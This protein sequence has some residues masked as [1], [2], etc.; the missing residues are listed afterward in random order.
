MR[1]LA[2][3]RGWVAGLG[4]LQ[5]CG[6]KEE[7]A[8]GD[9]GGA[10][11]WLPWEKMRLE[12]KSCRRGMENSGLEEGGGGWQRTVVGGEAE[13]TRRPC[14]CVSG[15]MV[16]WNSI[17]E[18]HVQSVGKI[19]SL[20]LFMTAASKAKCLHNARYSLLRFTP[21]PPFISP[22]PPALPLLPA[23]SLIFLC[24][25]YSFS[26]PRSSHLSRNL[27]FLGCFYFD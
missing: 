3:E 21:P 25:P 19:R 18:D 6:Y 16:M 22:P 4:E 17:T 2:A 23:A 8:A 26:R 13:P 9:A 15:I 10:S 1:F 7:T 11:L 5:K 14:M 20:I 27:L 24:F 12:K